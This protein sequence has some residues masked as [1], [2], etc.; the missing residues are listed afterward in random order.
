MA[1][2]GH[3]ACP[4][5]TNSPENLTEACQ[6]MFVFF[7]LHFEQHRGHTERQDALL[8]QALLGL[9]ILTRVTAEVL[10]GELSQSWRSS[11]SPKKLPIYLC[12][13]RARCQSGSWEVPFFQKLLRLQASLRG[14]PCCMFGAA[15]PEMP[16]AILSK[17]PSD[18][19]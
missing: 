2:G 9:H 4:R 16:S 12:R 15:K 11:T 7:N 19:R 1:R 5:H 10:R 14:G 3:E 18:E 13:C 6:F 17:S 8:P